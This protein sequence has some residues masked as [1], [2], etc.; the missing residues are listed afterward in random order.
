VSLF[1]AKD[2]DHVKLN[3]LLGTPN[4]P[5]TTAVEAFLA[6]LPKPAANH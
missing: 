5:A 6:S 1:A 4:D 3:N 2:T